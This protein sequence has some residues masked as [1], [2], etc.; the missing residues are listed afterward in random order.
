[1]LNIFFVQFQKQKQLKLKMSATEQMITNI[2]DLLSTG[3]DTM[4]AAVACMIKENLL[5][6]EQ[7]IW[8]LELDNATLKERVIEAPVIIQEHAYDKEQEPWDSD[9]EVSC[10]LERQ[11]SCG[12]EREQYGWN[13]T[14][15]WEQAMT[16]SRWTQKIKTARDAE[17]MKL[18]QEADICYQFATWQCMHPNCT[19]KHEKL[20][21]DH[22]VEAGIDFD[23]IR[24]IDESIKC[25]PKF[26][27]YV[28]RC[29]YMY[30]GKGPNGIAERLGEAQD[31]WRETSLEELLYLEDF[32][33]CDDF[34]ERQNTCN[35]DR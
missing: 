15:E 19:K 13:Q 31:K 33:K 16:D 22:D 28:K 1:M 12:L 4:D 10:G 34:P 5:G 20:V 24:Y 3:G 30:L 32:E 35:V 21:L 11:S 23:V 14:P 2:Y 7:S 25:D 29:G 18:C 6:L 8:R 26:A 27:D 17:Y 9:C